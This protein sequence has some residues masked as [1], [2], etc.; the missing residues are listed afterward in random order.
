MEDGR[1]RESGQDEDEAIDTINSSRA[2][3]A[4]K[5]GVLLEYIAVEMRNVNDL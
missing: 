2:I 1:E 3:I 4:I 5:A